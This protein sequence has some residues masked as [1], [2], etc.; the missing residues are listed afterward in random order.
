LGWPRKAGST[1]AFRGQLKDVRSNDGLGTDFVMPIT[2]PWPICIFSIVQI[3][4]RFTAIPALQ[5][6]LRLIQVLGAHCNPKA[7]PIGSVAQ[8]DSV[9]KPS[10]NGSIHVLQ[11]E[12]GQAPGV[13]SK[14]ELDLIGC[15]APIFAVHCY[16]DP[17]LA[18]LDQPSFLLTDHVSQGLT[19]EITTS[20]S[21]I[22][23]STMM[24]NV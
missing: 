12:S 23:C 6:L 5:L 8:N 11:W 21:A 13:I 18:C 19:R 10:G 20:F 14:V 17:C 16:D 15:Y 9:I 3:K 4:N 22:G 7:V 2:L 1:T 24:P